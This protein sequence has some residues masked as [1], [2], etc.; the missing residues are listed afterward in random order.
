MSAPAYL[1]S[2]PSCGS[3][4]AIEI[5]YGLPDVELGRAAERGEVVLGECVIGPESP[6][7]E[8]RACGAGLP[9]IADDARP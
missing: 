1:P 7:Y 9:W 2:C 5:V 4:D 6:R 3:R 8:C